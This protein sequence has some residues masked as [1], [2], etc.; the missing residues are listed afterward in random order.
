MTKYDHRKIEAK[1]QKEWEKKKIFAAKDKSAKPKYYCLVEFP[2]PSGDGLHVGHPRSY[3]AIDIL[4]RKR[5]MEGY[6]VLYPMGF[7]AFGLPS[8]NYAIKTG[9]H[10]AVTTEKNIKIFTNQLK[11]IGFSFDW[12]R[13]VITTDPEYYKWTQ[14]IFL[15]MY[16]R[17]L[18][19]K[20]KMSINWC[21]SCKTGL[22]NEEVVD[23]HCERCGSEVE[24]REKEQWLLKITEYADRLLSD[25]ELVD[26]PERVKT[27]QINWIGR[28][29]GAE[30]RF[31]VVAS[32]MKHEISLT[33]FTTRPDTLL[34]ATFMVVAPEHELIADGK[35]QIA[36]W[37]E[38]ENYIA[39][40]KKKS[41][42]ERTDLG[43]EKTGVELKGIKAINPIN[44]EKIPIFVADYVLISYGFGAIMAVPGHDF[45]DFEF[46]KKFN[47]PVAKVIEPLELQSF[48]RNAEDVASGAP[49]SLKVESECFEG[50]GKMV[51]SGQFNGLTSENGRKKIIELLKSKKAGQAKTNYKL[52]DWVFSRQR[53]WGEPIPMVYCENCLSSGEA[54][55]G[56]VMVP[57]KD[58]PVELPKVKNYEPS[59]TG[60][61]PLAAI[62]DWVNTKCP[63]CGG[64][65]KRETDTMPNWAGSN[66]Y[67]LRYIDPK[68]S[69]ELADKD[70][71]SYFMPVDWYN[72]GME[73]TTLH[74]LYS[75]F[76]YKF[77]YD[78]S[79]A[80]KKLG[81]EPYK[82]RT[83][84]GLVL[85]E[86][87]D[88]MSKSRGNVVNP[89]EI[90]KEF[91]ADTLR[92]Y[93][94]F[95][96]PFEQAI[97]WSNNGVIGARRFIERVWSIYNGGVKI[98]K[99]SPEELLS[100]THRTIKKVGNDIET[101]DYN[102]AVSS[103]MILSNKIIE[104]SEMD[105]FTAEIFLKLMSP[106]APHLSEE[107]WQKLYQKGFVCGQ[108]WP[109]YDESIAQERE[110]D[111]II[112]INGKVR[113]KIKAPL[114][115]TEQMAE[116][117]ARKSEKIIKHLEG[118]KV[119]NI[120]FVPERL[121]NFVV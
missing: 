13:Q 63:K 11:S 3:T 1:W 110:F 70:K 9:I 95:M 7:D 56:W 107:L 57:E 71:L 50:E 69:K 100:L 34:G 60:E 19:Y 16:E 22:A 30:I 116:A 87:G 32:D 109:E 6:N 94:M 97:P 91:G 33:V 52:R 8:E 48:A 46:A 121:I 88:K 118:K 79:A 84:H 67:F 85:G 113:D 77:L 75:R 112:Q 82:K 64:S 111:L 98:T 29:E 12:D 42:L 41:D 25:L 81:P 27:Q 65:A 28:S 44:Q 37:K 5:R 54:A 38:V 73:H 49:E 78:I 76:I 102:T 59:D 103:L 55:D 10:P 92:I 74:L 93:E 18:A 89:D 31:K 23:S 83:S 99:K 2:Y 101:Q 39:K 106:F 66:W 20:K 58:L 104:F 40:A 86:N 35:S 105:N 17:G 51:N 14:W 68:N 117:I 15:K 47:L 36:N 80:P 115:I 72:G 21:P 45:R 4:A 61:S 119:K 96:G 26:Y 90:V 53:Y 120:I 62:S 24:K 114:D 108:G 43:K